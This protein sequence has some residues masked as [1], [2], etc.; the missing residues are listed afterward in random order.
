MS[1]V[2]QSRFVHNRP[3]S[4]IAVIHLNPKQ[5]NV[6]QAHLPRETRVGETRLDMRVCPS[7]YTIRRMHSG[8]YNLSGSV[9]RFRGQFNENEAAI[10]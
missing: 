4:P 10:V 6:A 7:V 3:V 5:L 2:V 8:V 9:L 1:F